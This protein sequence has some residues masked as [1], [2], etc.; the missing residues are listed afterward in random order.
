MVLPALAVVLWVI[1]YPL[2]DTVQMATHAVN[3]FARMQGFIGLGNFQRL[4]DDA[5]FIGSLFRSLLWT[6]CVVLATTVIAL[7]VAL[8]LDDDFTGRGLARV[9]I[10][11]PWAVS[12]AMTAI[13]WRWALDGQFGMVNAVL[14]H[15]GLLH[16]PVEWLATASSSLPIAMAI[17]VAR[18]AALHDHHL[19]GWSVFASPGHLRGCSSR[20]R[21]SPSYL[22]LPNFAADAALHDDLDR[23]EHHLYF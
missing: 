1:A 6:V 17:G 2:D 19:P 13:V 15:L 23:A 3:R 20:R 7:P 8:I 4:L 18:L 5:I 14:F 12:V 22:T 11:L 9:I 21:K 10:M 16:Q